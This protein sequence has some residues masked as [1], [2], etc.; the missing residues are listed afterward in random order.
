VLPSF[1]C[2]QFLAPWLIHSMHL[3]VIQVFNT[4][5]DDPPSGLGIVQIDPPALTAVRSWRSRDSAQQQ[6][7]QMGGSVATPNVVDA[8]WA[9]SGALDQID[10]LA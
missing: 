1:T 4:V 3:V 8:S 9:G 5:G 10:P 6:S 2:K 7:T